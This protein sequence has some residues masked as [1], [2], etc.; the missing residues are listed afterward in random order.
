MLSQ[1][2]HVHKCIGDRAS[3]VPC[4]KMAYCESFNSIELRIKNNTMYNPVRGRSGVQL[5]HELM[6]KAGVAR[7]NYYLDNLDHPI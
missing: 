2:E 6:F 3:R 1:D 5:M 7:S 4:P